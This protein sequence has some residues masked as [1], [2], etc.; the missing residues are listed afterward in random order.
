MPDSKIIEAHGS[1]ARQQ[2][3]ECKHPYPGAEMLEAVSEGRVPRCTKCNGL[4]KPNIVFFGEQLPE[5]FH[6]NKMLPG[7]AD[8]CLIMGTSL[9]VQPFAS[10][11]GF[12]SEGVPRVLINLDR[13]GGLGSRADDVLVLGDCDKGIRKLASALGWSDE[14]QVLWDSSRGVTGGTGADEEAAETSTNKTLED[15]IAELSKD[16]DSALKISNEHTDELRAHL[17]KPQARLH[18]DG[19]LND[20]KKIPN[21]TTPMSAI[22]ISLPPASKAQA[23]ASAPAYSKLA[24]EATKEVHVKHDPEQSHPSDGPND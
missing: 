1:F 10:L 16:V 9:T 19:G 14:L 3:I 22:E 23:S 20:P 2:C 12:C 4:V 11:P 5:E 8:L 21:M 17:A 7:D 18:E 6:R 24:I 13:V 15:E